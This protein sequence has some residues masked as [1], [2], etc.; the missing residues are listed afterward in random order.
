MLNLSHGTV[1]FLQ[2][3]QTGTYILSFLVSYHVNID[4]QRFY[5][6]GT[7]VLH[8]IYFISVIEFV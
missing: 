2:V 4:M 5:S 6:V 1:G 8:N 3:E 7:V